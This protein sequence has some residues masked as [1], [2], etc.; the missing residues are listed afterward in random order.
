MKRY[1]FQS[2]LLLSFFFVGGLLVT[3]SQAIPPF[4]RKYQVSCSL[5]HNPY[6]RLNEFGE[7]F[8]LAGFRI[9][10][11]EEIYIKS[12]PVALEPAN[13]KKVWPKQIYPTTI[14]GLPPIGFR[15][16][17]DTN[18][19]VG[20]T[21]AARSTFQF[22]DEVEIL[23]A[24]SLGDNA[25]FHTEIEFEGGET[26]TVPWLRFERIFGTS[27]LNVKA[28]MVGGHTFALPGAVDGERITRNHYLY[29]D[30]RMPTPGG[31]SDKNRFRVRSAQPGFELTGYQRNWKYALGVVN[32][33]DGSASDNNSEKD[34]FL[35]LAAKV[36]GIGYDGSKPAGRDFWSK[37]SLQF[38]LFSYWGLAKIT[39]GSKERRDTFYRIGPDIRFRNTKFDLGAGYLFGQNNNPY[40]SL[41]SDSVDSNAWFAE[42]GYHFYPWLVGS[43]RY[44]GLRVDVPGGIGVTD[45][46]R[47]R[48]VP[49]ISA[50]LRANIKLIAEARLHAT[51]RS[52][53][54]KNDD[55]Q[56][57][58]RIDFAY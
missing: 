7:S 6:P 13:Y 18:V 24:G 53:T 14:P 30:W 5:C 32:G 37:N 49:S 33:N 50:L 28:G 58:L 10:Q 16:L 38:G 51:N 42:A 3:A 21:K 55:D 9:P 36:G 26:A 11:G 52:A 1:K 2:I 23:T 17:M 25:S 43:L 19:D 46:D 8:R 20:G 29:T 34:G 39:T 15:V 47:D 22:P 54:D 12:K 27:L 4:A 57:V 45:D 48:F 40:G 31:F 35:Q 44:E 56:V 41:T